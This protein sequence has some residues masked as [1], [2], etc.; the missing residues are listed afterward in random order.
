[1]SVSNRTHKQKLRAANDN[2]QKKRIV[3]ANFSEMPL[4]ST[5]EV[6]VFDQLIS[7]LQDITANDNSKPSK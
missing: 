5:V 2:L 1:M 3:L 7:D 4:I 6:E